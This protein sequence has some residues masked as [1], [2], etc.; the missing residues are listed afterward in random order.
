[1]ILQTGHLH[2]QPLCTKLSYHLVVLV[3]LYME[4][5]SAS[6]EMR[7]HRLWYSIH[8]FM[9]RLMFKK[10]SFLHVYV[11]ILF[12]SF[13]WGKFLVKTVV[14]CMPWKSWKKLLWKVFTF[15]PL[16]FFLRDY[17]KFARNRNNNTTAERVK[18]HCQRLLSVQR[19]CTGG[20]FRALWQYAFFTCIFIIG[21][22]YT[23]Q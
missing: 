20:H 10:L 21:T 9:S 18:S 13:L 8:A 1:M 12:R 2:I 7:W 17:P 19:K 6:L 22:V 11:F 15:I 3:R 23:I 14:P 4:F 5:E 16:S